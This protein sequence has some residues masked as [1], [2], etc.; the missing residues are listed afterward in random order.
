MLKSL[1]RAALG[2]ARAAGVFALVG[3]S[4]WRRER[5]VILCYHGVSLDDEHEWDPAMFVTAEFLR[6]RL[7]AIRDSGSTV[8][9][10]G[11][12]L[13]RLHDGTLPPRAVAV[14]FD[15]GNHDFYAR[16]SPLLKEFRTPATVYLATYYC[17]DQRPVFDP[18]CAYLLW[19]GR[20]TALEVGGLLPGGGRLPT[21]TAAERASSYREIYAYVRRA[22]LSADQKDVMARKIAQRL[23]VDDARIRERRILHLMSPDEVA[24][25]P[26]ELV[27]VQLH[28]HRHRTPRDRDLFTREITDNRERI[29]RLAPRP[30]PAE[31]FCYPSGDYD[32]R[33]VEWLGELGVTSATTCEPGAATRDTH[34]L[35]LPRIIDSSALSETEFRGWLSGVSEWLPRR[36]V[37][38]VWS[39]EAAAE[40]DGI[41]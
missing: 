31:H 32:A 30:Y 13:R 27:D 19:K 1:K 37:P 26:P 34:P 20:G 18:L 35:R 33:F 28:T 25:L 40:R 4:R 9:P 15:D 16:A 24:A 22:R 14:T 36:S 29:A 38:P 21:A 7:E 39:A 5:L 11:E 6:S 12:G 2:G 10:L 3:R 41:Q 17:A 23:G 8:L